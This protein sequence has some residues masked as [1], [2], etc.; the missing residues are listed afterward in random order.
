MSSKFSSNSEANTSE[1]LEN[2]QE[3][4]SD[5]RCGNQRI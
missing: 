1:F 4:F 5:I 3:M 2:L